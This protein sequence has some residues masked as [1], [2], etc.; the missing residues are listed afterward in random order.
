KMIPQT[1]PQ[2]DSEIT[3]GTP[4]GGTGVVV[5]GVAPVRPTACRTQI[6]ICWNAIVARKPATKPSANRVA[7]VGAVSDAADRA[8]VFPCCGRSWSRVGF[9]HNTLSASRVHN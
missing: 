6:P 3:L 1:P 9:N 2:N 8:I 5:Q 4:K 7:E